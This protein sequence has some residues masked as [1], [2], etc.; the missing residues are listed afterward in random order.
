MQYQQNLYFVP[1]CNI[2]R[3]YTYALFRSVKL[4]ATIFYCTV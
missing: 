3:I 4:E 1:Q 2:R